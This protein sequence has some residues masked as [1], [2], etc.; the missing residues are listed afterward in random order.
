[1]TRSGNGNGPV[2]G[3]PRR[4][5]ANEWARRHKLVAVL[6][7]ALLL[8]VAIVVVLT[9]SSGGDTSSASNPARGAATASKGAPGAASALRKAHRGAA[10][11]LLEPVDATKGGKW[12]TGRANRLLKVVMDDFVTLSRAESAAKPDAAKIA[13]TQLAAAAKSALGGPM[14]P[15]DAAL[16]RSA[17]KDFG[18]AGAAA[19][20]GDFGRATLLLNAGIADITQVTAAVDAPVAANE[21]SG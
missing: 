20:G 13:G 3:Q 10:L 16:Y 4:W 14:P 12:L 6:L 17:L 15:V 2:R 18:R 19:A 7:P 1:M 8:V 11:A 5:P 21:P 9:V